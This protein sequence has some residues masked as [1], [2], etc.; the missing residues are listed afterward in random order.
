MICFADLYKNE[1]N[2]GAIRA[3]PQIWQEGESFSYK[4]FPRPD[5]GILLFRQGETICHTPNGDLR[6]Q[7]GD[8]LFIG[9]GSNYEMSFYNADGLPVRD[10]MI[11][12]ELTDS[13]GNLLPMA[14]QF[15]VVRNADLKAEFMQCYRLTRKANVYP[16]KLK[17]AITEMLFSM[18]LHKGESKRKVTPVDEAIEYISENYLSEAVKISHLANLCHMS[19]A[20]FRRVFRKETGMSPKEYLSDLKVKRANVLLSYPD[21]TVAAIAEDLGFSDVSYFIRFYKKQTGKSPGK[22]K[23]KA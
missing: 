17:V 5:S 23:Y 8:A 20:N 4:D 12:F 6:L 14:N 1:Y 15:S 21:V 18:S 9:Q 7:K 16:A 11:N 19:E 13:K 3:L 10:R 2:V 22:F